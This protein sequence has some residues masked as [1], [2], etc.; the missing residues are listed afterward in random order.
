MINQH[1]L[2]DGGSLTEPLNQA[3]NKNKIK[4]FTRNAEN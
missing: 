2:W 1:T 4:K 3:V